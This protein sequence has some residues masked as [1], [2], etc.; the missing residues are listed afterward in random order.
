MSLDNIKGDISK[1]VSTRSQLSQFC[2]NM[3]FVSQFE[4]KSVVDALKDDN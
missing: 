1:G 4:P 3:A 2:L